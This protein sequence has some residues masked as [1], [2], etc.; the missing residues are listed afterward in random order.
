MLKLLFKHP[1]SIC[2]T[3][4]RQKSIIDYSKFPVINEAELEEQFVKGH[5]P[6]GSN[7]NKTS[8]CVLLKHVPSGIVIRCH[9]SRLL[10]RNREL[11]REILLQKLD[12]LFN[13]DMSVA[14]QK[15]RIA[16]NKLI[17]KANKNAKL[18][19]L[20][21]KFIEENLKNEES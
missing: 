4:F 13:G 1:R 19:E 3:I 14:E 11:A 9:E 20:K 10:Q 17:S 2:L 15:K 7:V 16:K 8:N 5:G 6:G 21:K 12:H 18:R